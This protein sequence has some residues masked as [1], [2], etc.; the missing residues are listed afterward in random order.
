MKSA[1][2]CAIGGFATGMITA[3]AGLKTIP[4][5][6]WVGG[7]ICIAVLFFALRKHE[8]AMF[9]AGALLVTWLLGSFVTLNYLL[10]THY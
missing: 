8:R 5:P 3:T 10:P 7:F 9:K 6:V 1:L 2:G 4:Y